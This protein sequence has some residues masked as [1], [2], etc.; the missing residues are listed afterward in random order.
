VE[1]PSQPASEAYLPPSQ[2][3]EIVDFGIFTFRTTRTLLG[4]FATKSLLY[5]FWAVYF[6]NLAWPGEHGVL[7]D[8][9]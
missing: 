3:G 8:F 4:V 7:L 9:T 2:S 1:L 5:T 6:Q